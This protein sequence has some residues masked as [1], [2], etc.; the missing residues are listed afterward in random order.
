MECVFQVTEMGKNEVKNGV[1]TP[2]PSIFHYFSPY[3]FK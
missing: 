3:L 1:W 2:P